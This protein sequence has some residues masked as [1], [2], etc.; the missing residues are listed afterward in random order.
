MKPLLT[1]VSMLVCVLLILTGTANAQDKTGAVGVRAGIGTDI[2]GGIAYGLQLN[3][4]LF[5]QANAL[6]LGLAVFGGTFEEES[7]NGYNDYFEETKILVIGAMV[8]YLFRY[9]MELNGPYILAGVGVGAISVEWE[10]RSDTDTSLGQL[11][12]NGGSMMSED[13][14]TAGFILNLGLGYRFTEMFDLRLQ[15]PTFIISGGEERDGKVVP[16]ITVTAGLSF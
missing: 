8:N 16:M 1:I 7:N 6:E 14:T 3:Y 10:E 15:V 5:Q 4:T 13:G 12:P 2:G 9:D 11:L